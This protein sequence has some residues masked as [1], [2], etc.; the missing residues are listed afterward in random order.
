M[1]DLKAYLQTIGMYC[2]DT[3]SKLS[4]FAQNNTGKIFSTFSTNHMFCV[5]EEKLNCW[6]C[7]EGYKSMSDA[8][9]A[10]EKSN[11]NSKTIVNYIRINNLW[12]GFLRPSVIGWK[13]QPIVNIQNK[14]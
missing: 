6:K 4:S 13:L 8:I 7:H 14:I 10:Y 3:Y 11:S 9:E 12:P 5:R 1:S 2:T